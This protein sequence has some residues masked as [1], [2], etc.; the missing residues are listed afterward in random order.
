MSKTRNDKY[1]P[2]HLIVSEIARDTRVPREL[3]DAVVNRYLDIVIEQIVNGRGFKM[4]NIFTVAYHQTPERMSPM[5]DKLVPPRGYIK[6]KPSDTL[7]DLD[8]VWELFYRDKADYVITRDTWNGA[9]KWMR[10]P[11]HR[12]KI[13]SA[14]EQRLAEYLGRGAAAEGPTSFPKNTPESMNSTPRARVTEAD[15]Y[16][17][18]L[19]DDEDE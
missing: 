2:H 4:K 16:Y 6:I 9:A 14:K 17:N 19:L 3:V 11:E 1:M 13:A 8:T 18:P 7:K 12:G 5:G 15:P 10:S